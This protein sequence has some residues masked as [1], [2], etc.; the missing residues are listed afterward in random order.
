MNR[1]LFA[2]SE[3]VPFIKTGGL[4]DVVGSL[5]KYFPKDEYDVRVVLPKYACMDPKYCEGMELVSECQVQLSWR[6]QYA[7][8]LKLVHDGVTF[9]FI[10]NEYYFAGPHPYGEI[11]QDAEKFAYF[12]RA[13]LTILPIIDF[14][15]D[16][17]HCNDWHTGLVPVFLT[18]FY[19]NDPFY[20]Y[21]RTVFTIH[22]L[23]FQGRWYIDAIK[24]VTGLPQ[25]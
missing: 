9:Y 25:E 20:K 19:R 22:N 5:P 14:Q 8:I 17:I 2:S 13:V 7:G 12:S 6:R 18:A 11:Y 1:I 15:P 16:I 24:D 4:A 21:I 23:K 10:D 3:V